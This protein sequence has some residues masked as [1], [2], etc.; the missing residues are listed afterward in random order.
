MLLPNLIFWT[1]VIVTGVGSVR[2]L[3]DR[4]QQTSLSWE[5]GITA[6]VV[7]SAVVTLLV[8]VLLETVQY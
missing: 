1:V 4:L 2:L 3:G 6:T 8:A 7:G 5:A